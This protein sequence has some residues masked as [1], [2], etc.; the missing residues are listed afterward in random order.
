MNETGSQVG[1]EREIRCAEC[2]TMLAE[3]MDREETDDGVFCRPC[4]N[5]LMAVLQQAQARQSEGINYPVAVVGGLAGGVLG[6]LVWWG[7][8]VITNIAFGL[9]AVVIGFAVGKGITILSGDKRSRGLQVISVVIA[10]SSFLYAGYLVNRTFIIKFFS[11]QGE[12]VLLPLLPD[13]ATFIQVLQTGFELFDLIFLA[14]VVYEAW[15]I[16]APFKLASNE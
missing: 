16:P 13:L 14:I 7:F 15:K 2:N 3:G 1:E 8:T 6:A 5:N 12:E 9:V 4:F 11:E 10:I